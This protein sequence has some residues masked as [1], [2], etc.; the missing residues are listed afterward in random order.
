MLTSIVPAIFIPVQAVSQEAE[1]TPAVLDEII[2]TGSIRTGTP[3]AQNVFTS[4]A[5]VDVLAGERLEENKG[6]GLGQT[7]SAL[8]GISFVGTG[9]QVGN[10]VVRGLSGNRVRVLSNSIGLNFQ[11]YGARHP[12]NLDP[13]LADRIEVVRGPASLQ[14]G[15]DAIGGAINILSKRP[16]AAGRGKTEF[17]GNLALA[18]STGHDSK[19]VALS[20]EA[21]RGEFGAVGTLVYRDAGLL[22]TPDGTTAFGGGTNNDPLVTGD[23]PFTDFS[24]VNG[25]VSLGYTGESLRGYVRWE[26]YNNEQN[27]LLP[28]P[29]RPITVGGLG[30][31]LQN[32][33]YQ[34]E[35]EWDALDGLILKPQL[36]FVRN[37]RRANKGGLDPKPLPVADGIA[38]TNIVRESSTSRL[39]LEHAA[40]L[41][42]EGQIGLEYVYEEQTSTGPTRLTP[43]GV[44][45]NTAGY[46]FE[47]YE[48]GNF[49]INAGLRHDERK[50]KASLG[51]TANINGLP[52]TENEL[53]KTYSATTGGLGV[54]YAFT[55][56][57]VLAGNIA[58]AF[59][60]PELFELY[61]NGAHNG[62]AAVQIGNVDL[63]EENSRTLDTSLRYRNDKFETTL[64]VYQT[65]FDG[66]VTLAGTGA[67]HPD[68]GL[69][70]FK[71]IQEDAVLRGGDIELVWHASDTLEL[72]SVAEIVRGEFDVSGADLPLLPADNIQLS[73]RKSFDDIGALSQPFI[74]LSGRVVREK[75]ASGPLEPFYQ[76][77]LPDSKFGTASTDGYGLIDISAGAQVG[78]VKLNLSVNNLTNKAYREFLDTYK[79]IALSPGRD[80]KFSANWSF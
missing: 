44:I 35:I 31:D 33:L 37:V 56:D 12:A 40:V 17:G 65:N 46:I 80:I 67:I 64:T 38:D 15:T 62:V 59:R 32:D 70:I 68:N 23:L 27:F 11:Q 75:A 4:P 21:A 19:V 3:V 50:Q 69:P 45:Q 34:A 77:D 51:R 29:G 66:Y 14:Y 74:E 79:S 8:P 47:Q 78:A 30:Q 24:Q 9:E 48:V 43:G 76:Y 16:P 5:D 58:T 61:A 26:T 18:Y 49:I 25:D 42:F 6:A 13:L 73:A 22:K 54:S 20:L 7:L 52:T 72:R 71:Y 53:S 2:V 36:A 39:I 55:P 41:G 60:A 28:D 57:L 10:P 63:N 1:E